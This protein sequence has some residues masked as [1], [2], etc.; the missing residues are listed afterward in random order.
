L[1]KQSNWVTVLFLLAFLA[2]IGLAARAYYSQYPELTSDNLERLIS[3]FGPAAVVVYVL[4]YLLSSPIPFLAPILSATGGLL[5]GPLLGAALAIVIAA[6]TSL[7]PFS[8][9][10]RLGREWVEAKLQNSKLNNIYKR[11]DSGNGFTFILL[12]RLVPVMPWELQNY[13]AGVTRV[14]VLTYMAAT[15][16]GSI[17][18]TVCLAIL[19]SAA[20]NPAS[21]GFAGAVALTAVVLITPI[22]VF[23][24]RTRK[25]P[26]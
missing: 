15:V 14:S 17:P 1:K 2:L 16:L 9:S 10:R 11:L 6:A 19:G 5:F 4:A 25:K 8:I 20:K 3:S 24:L 7:V 22:L 12:L 13:L 21:W 18:L 26:V 23:Y